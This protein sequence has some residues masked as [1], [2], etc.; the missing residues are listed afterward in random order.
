VRLNGRDLA[1]LTPE[2]ADHVITMAPSG[3]YFVDSYSRVDAA[4]VT[5]LRRA[6]GR[7]VRPLEEADISRL[8]A[9]GWAFPEPFT[10]KARDG[11]T[12]LYG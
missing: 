8:L 1:L 7:S 11:E 4:P 5:V 9:T 3:R 10:A 6:D 12:D 2:D